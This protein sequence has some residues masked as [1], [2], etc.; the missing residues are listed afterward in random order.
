MTE[1][2]LMPLWVTVF[3][4]IWAPVG[5]LI[6]L[7]IGHLLSRSQPRRQWIADNEVKEWRELLTTMVTSFQTIVQTDK[8]IPSIPGDE[9]ARMKE[10]SQARM[11]ANEVL[12]NRMFIARAVRQSDMFTRW[13]TALEQFDQDHDVGNFGTVF[14]GLNASILKGARVHIEKA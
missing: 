10:N 1:I 6:G 5:P 14:G 9:I 11:L 2:P 4:T 3:L 13:K 12:V 8:L 7:L